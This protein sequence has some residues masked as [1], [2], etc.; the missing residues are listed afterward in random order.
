MQGDMNPDL[1]LIVYYMA[2]SNPRD[3]SERTHTVN[4][5]LS[6]QTLFLQVPGGEVGGSQG[7]GGDETQPRFVH[8]DSGRFE[9]RFLS[10]R[11]EESPAVM[12]KDMGEL[13]LL[14]D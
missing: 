9:S 5:T 10:V 13:T 1:L 6:S 8:N 7:S 2:Q 14:S 3:P 11:I 4:R 12:L